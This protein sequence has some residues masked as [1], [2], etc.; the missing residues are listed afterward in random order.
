MLEH[1]VL[2]ECAKCSEII[3]DL[4]KLSIFEIHDYF[5]DYISD[6]FSHI[7]TSEQKV[8]VFAENARYIF[9]RASKYLSCV[10]IKLRQTV[11]VF[12]KKNSNYWAYLLAN[13]PIK[14]H[15]GKFWPTSRGVSG[16]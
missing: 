14:Y 12:S 15:I 13:P 8:G 5:L 6:E 1:F 3:F 10:G 4:K 9:C 7:W 16:W 2:F 11:L